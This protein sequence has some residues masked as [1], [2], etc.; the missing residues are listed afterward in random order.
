MY[1]DEY[2]IS[3]IE[4]LMLHEMLISINFRHAGNLIV[5]RFYTLK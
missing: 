2:V 1:S 5:L 4:I 3:I